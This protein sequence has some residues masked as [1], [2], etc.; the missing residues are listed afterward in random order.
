[1]SIEQKTPLVGW[2][3]DDFTG[4]AATLEVMAFAGLRAILFVD[5]PR[6]EQLSEFT[7]VQGI[8]IA[9]T[10][11]S[12]TPEW[13]AEHLPKYFE[14][15]RDQKVSIAHYKVCS[16]LDSAPHVGSIGCAIDIAQNTYHSRHVP[17]LIAAPKMRRYQ[18][19]GHLFAAAGSDVVRIDE[20]PTM[21][22][23]PV[24][25]ISDSHVARHL[26][27]QTQRQIATLSVEDIEGTDPETF[28]AK[29]GAEI[30]ACD[31]MSEAHMT[32][33][34]QAIWSTP[35]N[36]QFVVGS[37]GIEYALINHWR[38]RGFIDHQNATPKAP[39]VEQVICVSG[40]LSP[41]TAEQIE[42]AQTV[43]FTGI[44]VDARDLL[45]NTEDI[46]RKTH[47]NAL[48]V[49]ADGQSPLIYTAKGKPDLHMGLSVTENAKIGACLGQLVKS[50]LKETQINRAIISGG[51]TS[52]HAVQQLDVFAFEALA[53]TVPGASLLRAYSNDPEL[54]NLELA[55][56]GGQMG[57][58]DYFEWIKRGGGPAEERKNT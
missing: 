32:A 13:M 16:T 37:Q 49:I 25:P 56:K 27:H 57:T 11:R 20:H 4:S 42:Y 29:K 17:V 21:A 24:T 30:I 2:I 7:D 41:H 48:S 14:F 43:G 33:I 44:P 52:G 55:L 26:S 50:L 31:A 1:M 35:Q 34:G 9:T 45:E 38:A 36:P 8:G 19:F 23:H 40:S 51:D 28:F 12:Q 53:P 39:A 46:L 5:L 15:L 22:H 3:G 58:V 10:S 18:A 54:A 6:A 47:Q